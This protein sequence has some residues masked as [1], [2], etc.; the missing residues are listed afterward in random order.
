MYHVL[1]SF[2]DDLFAD[3]LQD[4]AQPVLTNTAACPP[5]TI[6]ELVV[7]NQLRVP[8]GHEKFLQERIVEL[9]PHEV[10]H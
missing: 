9:G 3:L 4:L 2:L 5:K 10:P 7:L 1:S 6:V 8:R